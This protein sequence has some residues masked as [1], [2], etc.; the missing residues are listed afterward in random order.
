MMTAMRSNPSSSSNGKVRKLF[1]HMS[2]AVVVFGTS[3]G[4]EVSTP[5]HQRPPRC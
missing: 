3:E 5:V 1:L 2:I 4:R